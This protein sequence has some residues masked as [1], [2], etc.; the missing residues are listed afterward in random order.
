MLAS[1]ARRSGLDAAATGPGLGTEWRRRSPLRQRSFRS[2]IECRVGQS[3]PGLEYH[4]GKNGSVEFQKSVT[5]QRRRQSTNSNGAPRTGDSPGHHRLVLAASSYLLACPAAGR[6]QMRRSADHPIRCR[7]HGF[8]WLQVHHHA[9]PAANRRHWA[10]LPPACSHSVNIA[11]AASPPRSLQEWQKDAVTLRAANGQRWRRWRA[12]VDYRRYA[13][14]RP[15]AV[16][17]C[18]S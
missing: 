3:F 5:G 4:N 13:L 2:S 8:A 10:Q 6:S 14:V 7:R 15:T 12:T 16:T 17:D 9:L 1:L 18:S 11:P